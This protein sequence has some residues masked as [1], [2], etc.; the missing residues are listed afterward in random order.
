MKFVFNSFAL[1]IPLIIIT[2]VVPKAEGRS[3]KKKMLQNLASSSRFNL[4]L[5]DDGEYFLEVYL[6]VFQ[7]AHENIS[8]IEMCF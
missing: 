7:I 3:S 4:L 8:L 6:S 2:T 1:Q 5:L